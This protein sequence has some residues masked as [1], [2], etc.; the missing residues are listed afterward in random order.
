V[1]KSEL[2]KKSRLARQNPDSLKSSAPKQVKW[3]WG[4]TPQKLR[5]SSGDLGGKNLRKN[6]GGTAAAYSVKQSVM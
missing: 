3:F 4:S 6:Q 2:L 5:N 1:G